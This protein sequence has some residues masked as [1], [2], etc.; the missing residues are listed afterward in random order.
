MKVVVLRVVE[1]GGVWWGG[2]AA[3][4]ASS[5]ERPNWAPQSG[6]FKLTKFD[7]GDAIRKPRIWRFW[8]YNSF[9]DAMRCA[10]LMMLESGGGGG[11]R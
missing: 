10:V 2:G 5:I 11:C 4:V 9:V 8:L 1:G 3:T 6:I 7:K